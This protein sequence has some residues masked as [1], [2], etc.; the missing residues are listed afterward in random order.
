MKTIELNGYGMQE[1]NTK[2]M[3]ETEGGSI[4]PVS[5]VIAIIEL[6]NAI[7]AAKNIRL[8]F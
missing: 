6:I 7:E 1:L 5:T 4:L 3:N 2:E 8:M